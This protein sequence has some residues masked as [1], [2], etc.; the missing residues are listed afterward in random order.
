MYTGELLPD[1]LGDIPKE[2][3][4]GEGE[5]FKE[6]YQSDTPEG[7]FAKVQMLLNA[8]VVKQVGATFLFV[9]DG[10]NSGNWFLDLKNDSGSVHS[11]D[12]D[13]KPDVTFKMD[14][15][16]LVAMFKGK[17]SATTAFMSGSLKISGNMAQAMSLDKLMGQ[18]KSKL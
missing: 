15:D 18:I 12:V 17:L 16:N 9:L 4:A 2:E 6:S 11:G 1:D 5:S 7:I 3:L 14:S 10:R 13:V 8:D